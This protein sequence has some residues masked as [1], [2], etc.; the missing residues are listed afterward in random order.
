MADLADLIEQRRWLYLQG[1][2]KH[3]RVLENMAYST[4]RCFVHGR[5]G[6]RIA[7]L[8]G[9]G[10]CLSCGRELSDAHDRGWICLLCDSSLVCGHPICQTHRECQHPNIGGGGA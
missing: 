4:L 8:N 5:K 6:V 2:P 3:P 7:E 9:P 10:P 1:R